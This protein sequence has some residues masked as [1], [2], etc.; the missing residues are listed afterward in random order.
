M[1]GVPGHHRTAARLR[2]VAHQEAVPVDRSL[3][4]RGGAGGSD[5]HQADGV[6]YQTSPHLNRSLTYC[7]VIREAI[8]PIATKFCRR[9]G[10]ALWIL[11]DPKGSVPHTSTFSAAI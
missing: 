6:V 2:H 9:P 10:F 4:L 5:Q 1:A 8:M 11:S 7:G 3:F